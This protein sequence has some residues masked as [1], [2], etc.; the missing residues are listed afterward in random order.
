MF[1]VEEEEDEEVVTVLPST[2]A[3]T[4]GF[5]E[6][7]V[8]TV[9]LDTAEAIGNG[10]LEAVATAVAVEVDEEEEDDEEKNLDRLAI[11]LNKPFFFS[12]SGASLVTSGQI[13]A[14]KGGL[15]A[16]KLDPTVTSH[17]SSLGFKFGTATKAIHK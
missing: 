13:I 4:E 12:G 9:L 1:A 10:G 5:D 8:E 15:V 14:G 7:F 3:I 2:E 16:G 11:Q 6:V 17:I